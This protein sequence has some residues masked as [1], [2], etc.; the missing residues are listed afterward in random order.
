[1]A[2]AT[3]FRSN[4]GP[5][6]HH[7]NRSQPLPSHN[8]HANQSWL[9]SKTYYYL[10]WEL[11]IRS[12][13]VTPAHVSKPAGKRK[14]IS[15]KISMFL[16][17]CIDGI[18]QDCINSIAD[19]LELLQSCTKSLIYSYG[20]TRT[21]VFFRDFML[22]LNMLVIFLVGKHAAPWLLRTKNYKKIIRKN[23]KKQLFNIHSIC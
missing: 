16:F 17:C 5:L 1:M 10:T 20:Y 9:T 6:T 12:N 7:R 2:T 8:D 19:A 18:V 11:S 13:Y 4:H 22:F 14:S 3:S 21:P 23:K 15:C